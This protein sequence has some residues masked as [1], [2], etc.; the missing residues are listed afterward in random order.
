M[1]VKQKGNEF[2]LCFNF[3]FFLS[4]DCTITCAYLH[5]ACKINICLKENRFFMDLDT[6]LTKNKIKY[7]IVFCAHIYQFIFNDF[8]N[9]TIVHLAKFSEI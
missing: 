8:M 1:M 9:C 5:K 6:I 4:F 7:Q 2:I 3:F